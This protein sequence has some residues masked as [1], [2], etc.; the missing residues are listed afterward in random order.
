MFFFGNGFSNYYLNP[1][2]VRLTLRTGPGR[3]APFSLRLG[4]SGG[5]YLRSNNR[6]AAANGDAVRLTMPPTLKTSPLDFSSLEFR[7]C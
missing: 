3:E 2:H 1:F 5:S 6:R 4:S 7:A